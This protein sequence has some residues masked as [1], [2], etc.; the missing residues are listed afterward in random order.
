MYNRPNI[1]LRE[2][3][4]MIVTGHPVIIVVIPVV[5]VKKTAADI[6]LWECVLSS[7]DEVAAST[8]CG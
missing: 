2:R 4:L 3:A 1:G 6:P 7:K 8:M 5:A